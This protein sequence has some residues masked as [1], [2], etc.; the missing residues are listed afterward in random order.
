MDWRRQ[1]AGVFLFLAGLAYS[2]TLPTSI[3]VLIGDTQAQGA[4][5]AFWGR[6]DAAGYSDDGFY[7]GP[8][9]SHPVSGYHELLSGEWGAAVYY[10]GIHTTWIDP[11]NPN[12]G[13]KAMWLTNLF[14]Y[15]NWYTNSD[16]VV[17]S[18]PAKQPRSWA[19]PNGNPA[20]QNDTAISY[21]DNGT[22][23]VRI[24]YEVVDLE[25]RDPNYYLCRSPMVFLDKERR[26]SGVLPSDRYILLQ[27]YTLRNIT[28][29]PLTDVEFYQFLHSHGA[30]EYGPAVNSTYTELA[31]DDPL[32]YYTPYNPIH[33]TGN[34]RYDITQWNTYPHSNSYHSTHRD[35][36]G[37]SCAQKPDWI[38][39]DVYEGGHSYD[40][41]KPPRG[42]HIH[43]ESR[44][45]NGVKYIYDSEVG[46]AMGWNI[47][48]LDPNETE[49]VTVAF[50][51]GYGEPTYHTGLSLTKTVDPNYSQVD[52]NYEMAY[53]L[54]YTNDSSSALT[55][56]ILTD[57]LPAGV[58][59]VEEIIP[60]ASPQP[61]I[62]L[63]IADVNDL[64]EITLNV[65]Q[66]VRLYVDKETLTEDIYAFSIEAN[67]A[68][69]N[70]GSIDNAE[71]DPNNPTSA[72]ILASPRTDSFDY[73]GP[74]QTQAE[75]IILSGASL[76]N[77]MNDG[78]LAS[79]VYTATQAGHAHLT[80]V[81]YDEALTAQLSEM[82]IH[83][84]DP[85]D[86]N[87]LPA[88]PNEP[89]QPA[90][91]DCPR[92]SN[93]AAG[94]YDEALHTITWDIGTIAANSCGSVSFRV[95]VN[96]KSEPGGTLHNEAVLSCDSGLALATLDTSVACRDGIIYVDRSADGAG[97]GTSWANAYTDL[98]KALTRAAGGCG[99]EIWAARGLYSPGMQV[100]DSF[101][102]PAGVS[103]YGG[104]VGWETSLEQREIAANPTILSGLISQDDEGYT[105]RNITVVMMGNHSLLDGVT[106]KESG[107]TL[108]SPGRGIYGQNV[109]FMVSNC[110]IKDNLQYGIRADNGNVSAKWCTISDNGYDGIYYFGNNSKALSIENCRIF[111][112]GQHGINTRNASTSILNSIL[113]SNGSDN[114]GTY[115]GVYVFYPSA[116]PVLK[117][118]SVV[119]NIHEGCYFVGLGTRYPSIRN[120]I[121]WGNKDNGQ[122]L[123]GYRTAYYSCIYD[124]N[125]PNQTTP[126]GTYH[127]ISC[128][129]VFAE[130]G[131]PESGVY[132]LLAA[133]PCVDK[134]DPALS[135]SNQMD[136]DGEDRVYGYTADMGADEACACDG[137][138]T[139][140]DIYNE[141]DWDYDGLV[142]LA[143]FNTFSKAWLS[144]DPND[145]AL[146]DPN[147]PM[148]DP[149]SSYYVSLTDKERWEPMCDFVTSG[150][151]QYVIDLADLMIWVEDSPWLWHACWRMDITEML[152]QQQMMMSLPEQSQQ[153]MTQQ[154]EAMPMETQLIETPVEAVP[155][156]AVAVAE[157]PIPE[158]SIEEQLA[159]IQDAA[160]WLE[161]LWLSEPELQS[162]IDSASWKEFMNAVY[163]NMEEL[164]N[165]NAQTLS[166]SEELQ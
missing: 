41:Y 91:P 163:E 142:N 153:L 13:K 38:D 141:Y 98:Q 30:D 64:D 128:N 33:E 100:T 116:S 66:S 134:G 102:L 7:Y 97:S 101:V 158:K 28:A 76:G 32:A 75:G 87:S 149:N 156:E 147:S 119:D 1:A 136:M 103:V 123:E 59:F 145:P 74:G 125:Y 151:S 58:D 148:N 70:L 21:I 34:F 95:K 166:E 161:E 133:S 50:M 114:S 105:T 155:M 140:D 94:V 81:N 159:D 115:Y 17:S 120:C 27:T 69:P 85:N 25:F 110:I 165:L 6:L 20:P 40:E 5:T 154:I 73:F 96:E 4:K 144:H 88:E 92:P 8:S 113:S 121:L 86:P 63:G 118:C 137:T 47:G 39:T 45:L 143:E 72:Q 48:T 157:I 42:S 67:M 89:V 56:C 68:D 108:A 78:N 109:D 99:E 26:C 53:T 127:N 19:D 112:N 77:V 122:Q 135:Y 22:M 51:F 130:G 160:K 162:E 43:V 129:P 152:Q 12:K 90:P 79:F 80:L 54:T 131:W 132:R 3:K 61:G 23:E 11:V 83:Q 106:V 60:Q 31:L 35:F 15:P 139:D 57:T 9:P 164:E 104:F 24:D 2:A 117:N 16:F 49:S 124:P 146:T 111:G 82:V 29:E 36:V 93:L 138:L 37:F 14:E 44:K 18:D 52:L 84:I 150:N 107:G 126:D 62:A 10:D 65:G 71:Y 55:N 46:G